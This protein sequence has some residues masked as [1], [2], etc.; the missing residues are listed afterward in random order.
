MFLFVFIRCYMFFIRCVLLFLLYFYML[1]YVFICF[2]ALLYTF[3][4]F[5][6]FLCVFI[7]LLCVF[8]G[9]YMFLYA[10]RP[11]RDSKNYTSVGFWS[12]WESMEK[13][14]KIG[15]NSRQTRVGGAGSNGMFKDDSVGSVPRALSKGQR[16]LLGSPTRS[17]SRSKLQPPHP[18]E[19]M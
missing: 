3:V 9:C 16:G 5:Y 15:P 1:L 13:G 6:V 4:C 2:Y 7:C 18:F 19:W 17:H 10:P 14:P 8:I 12:V 11:K